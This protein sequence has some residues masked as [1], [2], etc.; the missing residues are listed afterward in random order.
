MGLAFWLSFRL[1]GCGSPYRAIGVR[2]SHESQEK[3]TIFYLQFQHLFVI[4]TG[5]GGLHPLPKGMG[6]CPQF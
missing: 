1:T 4:L 5:F 6:H 2:R 3:Y